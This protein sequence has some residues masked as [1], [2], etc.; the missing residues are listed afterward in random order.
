[1]R[2]AQSIA[3]TLAIQQAV[4]HI[5]VYD[6]KNISIRDFIQDIV[7]AATYVTPASESALITAVL[8]RLTGIA[9][10]C[11]RNKQ[12]QRIT[13]LIDL[14]KERF[15]PGKPFECYVVDIYRDESVNDMYDRL[16]YY[17]SGART[18]LEAR[19]TNEIATTTMIPINVAALRAFI[20]GL[21]DDTSSAVDARDPKTLESAFKHAKHAEE[22]R[23]P[24]E[25][26]RH[27]TYRTHHPREPIP[28]RAEPYYMHDP[29][30]NHHP[31]ED[32]QL[33]D[34]YASGYGR[35][36][37]GYGVKQYLAGRSRSPSP[38][39]LNDGRSD[40]Q[41]VS[42]IL[43][44]S[45]PGGPYFPGPNRPRF[46]NYAYQAGY[47]PA[48]VQAYPHQIN[49]PFA[50]AP[51]NQSSTNYSSQGHPHS[52]FAPA[53]PSN[54]GPYHNPGYNAPA[55]GRNSPR[56]PSPGYNTQNDLNS[57]RTRQTDGR[58]GGFRESRAS[59]DGSVP[60]TILVYKISETI[61]EAPVVK[62]DV[63]GLQGKSARLFIDTGADV[64]IIKK[65]ALALETSICTE[66]TSYI[67][68]VSLTRIYTLGTTELEIFDKKVLF[69]VVRPQF[70]ISVEGILGRAYLRQEGSNVS[71]FYNAL[72]TQSRPVDPIPFID[73]ESI[74]AGIEIQPEI[75]PVPR[76]LK[77]RARTRQQIRVPVANPELTEGY[78]PLLETDPGL[79]IGNA[80]VSSKNGHCQVLAINTT[81]TDMN[82]T[83]PHRR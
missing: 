39:V 37:Q 79:L 67:T 66:N 13:E 47:P 75:K 11:T 14:L 69:H 1:M 83:V 33:Y 61:N 65:S 15:A 16:H 58:T 49:A 35:R 50:Q 48:H 64:N 62:L 78:M 34:P 17:L 45:S 71:F 2:M 59:N 9:R 57:D 43:R 44:N 31:A 55:S 81:Q 41:V 22:R 60:G 20:R 82:I 32:V 42:G 36:S 40:T 38:A 7:N 76:I 80:V 21:P 6:G 25:S 28:E 72:I 19:H 4:S 24:S 12:F 5:P 74:N 52:R 18:A 56:P 3:D 77:I 63:S 30:S 68:G 53:A 29:R 54:A 27:T 10:E 73:P 46:D 70:P 8:G 23:G 26:S 51:I